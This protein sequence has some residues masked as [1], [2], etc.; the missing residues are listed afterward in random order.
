MYI[1][2]TGCKANNNVGT[3]ELTN[4]PSVESAISAVVNTAET[5]YRQNGLGTTVNVLK[6]YKKHECHK[7][8]KESFVSGGATIRSYK[9]TPK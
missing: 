5:Y 3:Y 1:V 8:M 9:V 2:G 4:H 7:C 6:E